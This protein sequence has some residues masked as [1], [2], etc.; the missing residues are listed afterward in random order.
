MAA[1]GARRVTRAKPP[2]PPQAK[3]RAEEAWLRH[4]RDE[5]A[6]LDPK[7]GEETELAQQRGLMSNRE[8]IAEA[9]DAALAALSGEGGERA[10]HAAS[11]ALEKIRDKAGARL[12]AA[13]A[14]LERA[15]IETAEATGANRGRGRDLGRDTR[16]LETVEE[17]LFALRGLARKHGVGVDALA[18]LGADVTAK[19]GVDRGWRRDTRQASATRRGR[20]KKNLPRGGR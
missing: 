1:R 6:A 5:I 2:R 12:D 15:A 4:V 19:L 18:D 9:L 7:P 17:R 20:G 10:L 16:S 13:L 14:A 8:R 3:A 11:R